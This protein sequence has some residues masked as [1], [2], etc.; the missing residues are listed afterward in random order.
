MRLGEGKKFTETQWKR[1]LA[2]SLLGEPHLPGWIRLQHVLRSV[3]SLPLNGSGIRLLDA[4]CSRGDLL[5]FLAERKPDWKFVGLELEGDRIQMAESI[6]RRANLQN[7]SYL[8]ADICQLPFENEFDVAVC[9]DVMEHIADDRTAIANLTRALKRG[10]YLVIT[11]PSVPQP[12][13]LPTVKWRERRIGFHPSEY[14]HVRDGYSIADLQAL[15]KGNGTEPIDIRY[16]FGRF[17]TMCFD[18]FFSIGDSKPNL[19]AYIMLFPLLK[20][21]AYLDLYGQPR[22]GAA[23]L[24]IA[25]KPL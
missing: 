18:L 19:F 9:S 3:Q 2:Y 11:S 17:G 7:I 8:R 22:Q 24:G 25:R 1:R 4:G 16:T 14:G 5:T 10:G 15:F 21:L 13:H 6:R 20:A 12:K 23:V